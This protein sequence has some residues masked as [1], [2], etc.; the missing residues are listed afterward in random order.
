MAIPFQQYPVLWFPVAL[1]LA[2]ATLLLA[3]LAW[4]RR[5]ATGAK[6]LTLLLLTNALYLLPAS[7][8]VDALLRDDS[9]AYQFWAQLAYWLTPIW[10][11]SL[12]LLTTAICNSR[13]WAR[14]SVL[15][16]IFLSLLISP[17]AA[18][19]NYQAIVNLS[20]PDDR[21]LYW[22][23][24]ALGTVLFLPYLLV[25]GLIFYLW[26]STLLSTNRSSRRQRWKVA[27]PVLA[28]S[29]GSLLYAISWPGSNWGLTF[30]LYQLLGGLVG[31]GLLTT[32]LRF[33]LLAYLPYYQSVVF[34]RMPMAGLVLDGQQRILA[35]NSTTEQLFQ[36]KLD[37]VEGQL[38]SEA[39]PLLRDAT[40]TVII[41]G[42][43]YSYDISPLSDRR[44]RVSGQLIRLSPR[45]S[46][47]SVQQL[48]HDLGL[49]P[50][51]LSTQLPTGE[52]VEFNYLGNLVFQYTIYFSTTLEMVKTFSAIINRIIEAAQER[53]ETALYL[54][55]D[56]SR[57]Q[58]T[59]RPARAYL[60]Q[61]MAKWAK[62]GAFTGL[63]VVN[64][65]WFAEQ[66][67]RLASRLQPDLKLSVHLNQQ[68]ALAQI[69]QQQRQSV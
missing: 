64:P 59:S 34:G 12:L 51:D 50:Q 9:T 7:L 65:N 2:S 46:P 6:A 55:I 62:L 24:T 63:S 29:L 60:Q 26:L 1:A 67:F 31:V 43:A 23:M 3:G 45:P 32:I 19:V 16:P 69:R 25:G 53:G 13:N 58:S 20:T 4:R 8:S 40:D 21:G 14:L 36:T 68:E 57:Q 22:P 17:I 10:C 39:F 38:L 66:A 56:A 54:I 11:F 61:Q 42:E 28:M 27:L 41:D 47:V 30:V 33:G 5:Q 18:T 15:A 35:L 48:H 52:M 44:G 49:E 37:Q